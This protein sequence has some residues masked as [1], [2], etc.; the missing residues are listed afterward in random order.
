[1]AWRKLVEKRAAL[2]GGAKFLKLL[3]S[4][5][6]IYSLRRFGKPIYTT[7][8]SANPVLKAALLVF[9]PAETVQRRAGGPRAGCPTT[10]SAAHYSVAPIARQG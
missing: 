5:W 4:A 1:M 9:E 10:K 2:L 6:S 8:A 7:A 3:S